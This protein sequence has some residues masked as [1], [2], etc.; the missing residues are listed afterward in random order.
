VSQLATIH[1]DGTS[2][3]KGSSTTD[4]NVITQSEWDRLLARQEELEDNAIGLGRTRFTRRLE[5][6]REKEQLS[7][8]GG[9]KGLV[10]GGLDELTGLI[11]EFCET[12]RRGAPHCALKWLR[13][14]GEDAA[15]MEIEQKNK[16]LKKKLTREQCD[17][18]LAE[19]LEEG[20]AKAAYMTLK[21]ILD[22]IETKR[23][24]HMVATGIAD[25]LRD[26]L[27]YRRFRGLAPKL[28]EYKL[29]SFNTTSYSYMA[30]SLDGSIKGLRCPDCLE[31]AQEMTLSEKR[32]NACTHMASAFDDLAISANHRYLLGA[33]LVDLCISATGLVTVHTETTKRSG[34]R[35]K[36][37]ARKSLYVEAEPETLEWLSR[38]NSRMETM[39]PVALPMVVPP[40]QWAPGE[41]GGYRFALRGRHPFVRGASKAVKA[42]LNDAPMP[43]VY[44]AVNAIQNTAWRVNTDVLRVV[45]AL[46]ERGGGVAGVPLMDLI[47]AP[48]KPANIGGK[49]RDAEIARTAWKRAAH[50]VREQNK[51]RARDVID[52]DRRLRVAEM[53]SDEPAI[54]FPHT[55]DFR[56]RVYPVSATFTPQGEDLSKGLLTFATGRPIGALGGRWLAIHGANCLGEWNG[57]KVSQMTLD[58]RE[59]LVYD[60]LNTAI[61]K[62]GRDPIAHAW[63]M[64]ADEPIQFL[65]FCIEWMRFWDSEQSPEFISTLP[66]AIDGTCNG[67]QH[68]SALLRDPIGGEAVN[69]VPLERPNDIYATIAEHVTEQ[70]EDEVA[71]DGN[72]LSARWLKSQLVNRKLTKRPT[73]TFGYG[74]KRFGFQAQ[75]CEYVQTMGSSSEES[76]A[77]YEEV[78][79]LFA[80]AGESG[81]A[82]PQIVQACGHM[83]GLIWTALQETVVAAS[84]GMAWLQACARQIVKTGK[85]VRW[86]VPGTGFLVEQNYVVMNVQQITTE[87]AGRVVKPAVYTETDEI[88]QHK[89]VNAIAPNVVHSLDAAALM[90]C[91]EQA[92]GEGIESF[93]AIHDSYGC[94][95]GD[96]EVLSRVTRRA[97]VGLYTQHDVV[98][99]LAEQFTEQGGGAEMPAVP[100]KGTLDVAGVLASPYFFS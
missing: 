79:T 36:N 18:I 57:Q 87:I 66:I 100:E 94:L 42:A 43:V 33:K 21:V 88:E 5:K 47:E 4:T 44:S 78:K 62:A 76:K 74:S 26:E 2:D 28:Y 45:Q 50:K 60:T 3:Q 12:P 77:K 48:E 67:L 38:R 52:F 59:A 90:L 37:S 49:D 19:K 58:E 97:F 9:A 99:E 68:F 39:W 11:R 6:A 15:R 82:E 61:I 89:Q 63:W 1:T 73:M 56:G 70:L 55:L 84:E 35:A 95:A 23:S 81:D 46:R 31:K 51:L 72:E 53:M 24:L 22:S 16:T 7:T 41:Q 96:M 64:G 29:N 13:L 17:A 54:F 98:A 40:L 92:Q 25:L 80:V 71:K 20:Y 83:S 32:A 69:L 14:L 30:R 75:L 10:V 65:A 85:G 91:I 86:T 34:N 93:A 27:R 8:F